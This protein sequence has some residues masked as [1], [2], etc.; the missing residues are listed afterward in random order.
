MKEI[1]KQTVY[2]CSY[3]DQETTD[4]EH[5]KNCELNPSYRHCRTCEYLEWVKPY[6]DRDGDMRGEYYWCAKKRN[7]LDSRFDWE[8]NCS[9]HLYLTKVERIEKKISELQKE[10]ENIKK[11]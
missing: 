8:S 5:E 1:K 9:D 4:S 6:R 11:L 2:E 10:L 3:C 7:R